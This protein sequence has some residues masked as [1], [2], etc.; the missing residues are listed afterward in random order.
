MIDQTRRDTVHAYKA[1]EIYVRTQ[2]ERRMPSLRSLLP[3]LTIGRSKKREIQSYEEQRANIM[4][5]S[6]MF[7]GQ[8]R[9]VPASGQ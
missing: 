2:N 1:V 8:V 3:D 7:G 4:V 9:E 5:L 6:Q